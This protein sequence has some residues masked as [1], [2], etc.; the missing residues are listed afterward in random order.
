MKRLI[1][2]LSVL[3]LLGCSSLDL[4]NQNLVRPEYKFQKTYLLRQAVGDFI[5]YFDVW[6]NEPVDFMDFESL[7]QMNDAKLFTAAEKITLV[8][9]DYIINDRVNKKKYELTQDLSKHS[10]RDIERYNIVLDKKRIARI[11]QADPENK[12]DFAITYEGKTYDLNGQI[13]QVGMDI[14]SFEFTLMHGDDNL[15][16]IFKEFSYVLNNYEIIINRQ[17]DN[18]DDP[19]F[20]CLAVFV[21]QVLKENGYQYK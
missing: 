3:L 17:F 19:L 11:V 1:I 15:G 7:Q 12:F 2:I 21:H 5:N 10:Y 20:I 8:G 6:K 9:N 18:I 16:T 4:R 13:K 14:N